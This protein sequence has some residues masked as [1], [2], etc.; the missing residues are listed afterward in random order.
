LLAIR[1]CRRRRSWL[2]CDLA[3]SG[4]KTLHLGCVRQIA[5]SGFATAAQPF[6]GKPT[7]TAYGQN[8]NLNHPAIRFC[9]R[10][11]SCR[12]GAPPRLRSVA[13]R[14]QNRTPWLCQADCGRRFATAAQPFVGKPTPTAYG[15]NQN[16]NH[17]AIRFC[18]RRRSCRGGAPPCLRSAS[19]EGVG[20]G[21]PAICREAAAKP[22]TLVV[23]GR[24]RTAGLRLLRSRS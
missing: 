19:A 4:S 5:D 22:D 6:V 7:P 24:S 21:L 20:A 13:K 8:Q 11:R 1:F 17:P 14:Q 12:G 15:Q 2:A 18:R 23:S 3:R 16:L 10:R 9:R